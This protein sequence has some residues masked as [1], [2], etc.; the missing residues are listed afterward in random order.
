MQQ[1]FQKIIKGLEEGKINPNQLTEEFRQRCIAYFDDQGLTAQEIG[2][3]FV[4][5]DRNVRRLLA[6]VNRGYAETIGK[7]WITERFGEF[8]NSFRMQ[9]KRALRLS[10]DP[11]A[12]VSEKQQ[13][14]YLAWRIQ[15]EFI[16]TLH[17]IG[18]SEAVSERIRQHFAGQ[19]SEAGTINAKLLASLEKILKG[20]PGPVRRACFRVYN[21]K[22]DQAA[23]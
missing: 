19:D 5:S 4:M 18:L 12:T 2:D 3:I 9:Y 1:P 14:T 6:K 8:Y 21:M 7:D 23:I 22:M 17:A 10:N 16:Q 20:V 13:G 15:R 11:E